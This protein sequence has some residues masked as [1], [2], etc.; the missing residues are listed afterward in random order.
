FI[1]VDKEVEHYI[2]QFEIGDIVYIRRKLIAYEFYYIVCYIE[3]TS[4]LIKVTDLEFDDILVIGIGVMITGQTI[5]TTK[6]VNRNIVLDFYI[7]EQIGKKE[8]TDF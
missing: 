5:Q 6:T 8:P 3:V 7:E 4:T 2:N 1:P